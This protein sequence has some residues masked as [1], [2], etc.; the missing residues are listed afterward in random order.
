VVA[1]GLAALGASNRAAAAFAAAGV[2]VPSILILTALALALA[3]VPAVSRLVGAR[4]LGMVGVYLFLAVIGAFCDVHALARLGRVGLVLLA[5]AG[6]TV[7]FHGVVTFGAA[8]LFRMDLE[9]AAV[10]SQ[11]NVGGSTSAL[12][13]AKSLGREDLLVPGILLG[14]LGNAVGTFLGFLAVRLA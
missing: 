4:L 6:L 5:F 11:A 12:A 3:Q 10:A 9:G 13:L 14:S 1:L 2:E 8:W 7:L